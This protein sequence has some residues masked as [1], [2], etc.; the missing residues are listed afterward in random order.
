M[1]NG[2]DG[3]QNNWQASPP[4]GNDNNNF[5]ICLS[6]IQ[7]QLCLIIYVGEGGG[8]EKVRASSLHSLME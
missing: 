1:I 7:L 8:R 4:P 6:R 5:M 2:G 3:A